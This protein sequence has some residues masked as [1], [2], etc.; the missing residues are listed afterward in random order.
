MMKK[1]AFIL[2]FLSAFA[3]N[4]Q[5]ITGKWYGQSHLGVQVL[6]I[7][8]DIQ[9]TDDGWAGAMQSPDQSGEW[10]PFTHI[11]LRNDTLSMTVASIGF[12]YSGKVTGE[13][14]EGSFSQMGNTFALNLSRQEIVRNRPQ[15]PKP[16]YPYGIE[17][18]KFRNEQAGIELA[19]TLT[20]P[21]VG[22]KPFPAVILVT[23]SGPQDRDETIQG[24]RP[25]W[26]IADR[27]TQQGIAVLRYDDRGVSGSEGDYA[28]ATIDDFAGD[29]ASA[30]GYLR[31]HPE[32]A[33]GK[34]GIIGHSEGGMIALMLAKNRKVDFIVSLAGPGVDGKTLLDMQRTAIMK[35]GGAPD[36]YIDA[37]NNLMNRAVDLVLAIEN[38]K[39]L[40]DSITVL[41]NG[42]PLENAV[43]PTIAQLA[44]PEIRSFLQYDP[45]EYF[46]AVHCPVLVL[47]G[48]KDLQVPATPNLEAI[49]NGLVHNP[50]VT[51]ISYPDLNHLFQTAETGLP[52]EYGVIEETFN[53][54]VLQDITDW[55]QKTVAVF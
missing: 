16:K 19:G 18:V 27:L 35:T 10:L 39:E 32:I 38:K 3:A 8:F 37:Y 4:A 44:T 41:F 22:E 55:I 49:R 20:L 42:T 53:R 40:R 48:E 30:I 5:E 34:V 2:L 33:A 31:S 29:A 43:E 51:V 26:I 47:N 7:N 17:E 50:N 13:K 11:E 15:E 1:I 45:K 24:H 25:F 12:T 21:W 6:R 52:Q 14:L 46:P 9:H 36:F 28:A 54:E 23:G